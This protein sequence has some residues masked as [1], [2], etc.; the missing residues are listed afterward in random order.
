VDN[1]EQGVTVGDRWHQ[2]PHGTDVVDFRETDFLALHFAPDTVDVLGTPRHIALDTH[3]KQL[4]FESGHQLADILFPVHA[5]FG[6]QFGYPLVLDR[7]KVAE[8][9][10]FQLPL[11]M[12]NTQAMGQGGV[13]IKNFP[14]HTPLTL[15]RRQLDGANGTGALRQLDQCDA[16]IVDDRHQHLANLCRLMLDIKTQH[17]TL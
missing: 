17:L 7:F 13:Y 1:T 2:Y 4:L 11:D 14:R 12:T 3:P 10:I 16:H 9:Q 5:S 8:G 15:L 6:Q